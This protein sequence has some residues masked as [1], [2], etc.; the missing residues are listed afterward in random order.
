VTST[1]PAAKRPRGPLRGLRGASVALLLTLTS[2]AGCTSAATTAA[3]PAAQAEPAHAHA[4]PTALPASGDLASSCTQPSAGGG[5][6]ALSAVD[7]ISQGDQL[8]IAFTMAQKISA[9]LTVQLTASPGAA[10]AQEAQPALTVAA[11]VRGDVPV[12]LRLTTP[13]GSGSASAPQDHLHVMDNQLHV[14]IPNG[15]LTTVGPRWHWRA[16]ATSGADRSRCPASTGNGD[17]S[18][19]VVVN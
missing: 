16:T 6:A 2:S 7:L 5:D 19:A 10:V 8:V 12:A 4:A 14:G 3:A 1:T 9:D 13:T 18:S 17:P 15:L 11:T